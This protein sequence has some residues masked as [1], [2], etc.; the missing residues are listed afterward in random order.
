MSCKATVGALCWCLRST[1]QRGDCYKQS[2]GD[3]YQFV[4]ISVRKEQRQIPF[5]KI[6]N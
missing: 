5:N 3:L 1:V 4:M 6:L 2:G